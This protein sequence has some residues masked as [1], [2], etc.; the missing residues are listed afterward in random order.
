[1]KL[2]P[3]KKALIEYG[4][5]VER[6][7]ASKKRLLGIWYSSES[8][9]KRIGKAEIITPRH[10]HNV[11]DA[12]RKRAVCR[13]WVPLKERNCNN[14]MHLYRDTKSGSP[15]FCCTGIDDEIPD[16]WEPG[17]EDV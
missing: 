11:L 9:R 13:A 16:N 12:W 10:K 14:C 7:N 2:T 5:A 17:K 6:M 3:E 8:I 15:C 1:M 4:K